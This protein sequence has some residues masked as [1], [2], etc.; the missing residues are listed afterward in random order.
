M[1]EEKSYDIIFMDV[2]M[3]V[4]DGLETTR[5]IR[6]YLGTQPVIIAMTANAVSGDKQRCLEAGMDDYISK[7]FRIQELK[8]M[9]EKWIEQINVNNN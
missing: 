4:K 9:I 7:P 1:A 8:A 6:L 2:Q 5:A 3:P